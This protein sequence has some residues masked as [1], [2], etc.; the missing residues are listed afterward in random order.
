MRRTDRHTLTD[1]KQYA[2]SLLIWCVGVEYKLID[3]AVYGIKHFLDHFP[4]IHVLGLQSYVSKQIK[5]QVM[6]SK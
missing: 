6:V 5:I 3:E 4:S 1:Q 2:P